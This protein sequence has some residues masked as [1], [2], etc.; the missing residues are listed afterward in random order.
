MTLHQFA[1]DFLK[2]PEDFHS[3]KKTKQIFVSFDLG[4]KSTKPVDR[5]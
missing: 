5:I 2:S 1:L 4:G 3:E